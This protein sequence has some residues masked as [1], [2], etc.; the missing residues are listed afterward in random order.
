[1]LWIGLTTLILFLI[2]FED[3]K[4]RS[5]NVLSFLVLASLIVYKSLQA[6]PT[7]VWATYTGVNFAYLLLMLSL[8]SLYIYWK[9]KTWRLTSFIG[10]GDILF[11]LIVALLLD[12]V[13]FLVFNTLTFIVALV[14]HVLLT[15]ISEKYERLG[16]I[17]LAGF[18]SACLIVLI[19]FTTKIAEPI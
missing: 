3:F 18:Q 9:H 7:A 13:L 6:R 2:A 12:P 5:V 15:R 8:C 16:T 14:S 1:M 11:I 10:V 17:P 4:S 19:F